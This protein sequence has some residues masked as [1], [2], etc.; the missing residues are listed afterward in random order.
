[1]YVDNVLLFPWMK[2]TPN[3]T[4]M[5]YCLLNATEAPFA[6]VLDFYE[7][8]RYMKLQSEDL[9][10]ILDKYNKQPAKILIDLRKKYNL[11]LPTSISIDR[12]KRLLA[13]Y[14]VPERYATAMWGQISAT[15][16]SIRSNDAT[17]TAHSEES[18]QKSDTAYDSAVDINSSSFDA[19][20]AL[21]VGR[22]IAP[23]VTLSPLDNLS[24]FKQL[25]EHG[26]DYVQPLPDR[27]LIEQAKTIV[28]KLKKTHIFDNIAGNS[29]RDK[30]K[31]GETAG[32]EEAAAVSSPL[33]LLDNL[34]A[35]RS[36]AHIVIRRKRG[37]KGIVLGY[38]QAFDRHLNILVSDV[39]ETFVQNS[40]KVGGHPCIACL[41]MRSA[42]LS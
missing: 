30:H 12:V 11:V 23:D 28:S 15:G 34:M 9:S 10:K 19:A 8:Y 40:K 38:I 41:C 39:D 7:R 17:T 31:R 13:V 32:D 6:L 35:S 20:V 37:V 36:R 2:S 42:L 21:R 5:S 1:M 25:L 33:A 14:D 22:I 27:T 24:K 29:Q 26:F 4:Y 18:S 3:K 16:A